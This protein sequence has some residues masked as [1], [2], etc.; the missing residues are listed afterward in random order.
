MDSLE[1][2]AVVLC[3][4]SLPGLYQGLVAIKTMSR[5]QEL[6][7]MYRPHEM[8]IISQRIRRVPGIVVFS[9]CLLA[10]GIWLL[11]R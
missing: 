6:T 1:I 4:M 10:A 7:E 2:L 8:D 9:A 11:M 5:W 3:L